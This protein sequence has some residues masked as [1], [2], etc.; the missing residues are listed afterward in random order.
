MI[1]LAALIVIEVGLLGLMLRYSSA[2]MKAAARAEDAA[3]RLDGFVSSRDAIAMLLRREQKW[4]RLTD[5]G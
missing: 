2:S 1:I 4:F 3:R 5:N